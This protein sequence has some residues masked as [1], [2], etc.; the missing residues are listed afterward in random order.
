MAVERDCAETAA[1]MA[2]S[3]RHTNNIFR[4][5]VL[6]KKKGSNDREIDYILA[7]S[8]TAIKRGAAWNILYHTM[9]FQ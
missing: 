9:F 3:K 4:M 1:Q 8:W 5:V 7:L 6:L 2:D